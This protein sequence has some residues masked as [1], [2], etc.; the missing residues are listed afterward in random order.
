MSGPSAAGAQ[1]SLETVNAM[2]RARFA[3]ALGAV[4]EKAPWIVERAWDERPFASVAALCAAILRVIQGLSRDAQLDFLRAHPDLAGTALRA[5]EV[6]RASQSEQSGAGL[7]RLGDGEY[8]RFDRLNRAYR[9]KFGFPFIIAVRNHDKAS[10]LAAFDR[11]LGNDAA[12]EIAA[13]LAEIG[14]IIGFRLRSRFA[15]PLEEARR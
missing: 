8:A 5:G 14:E 13:A 9:E 7:D 4:V 11:R 10:I 1:L 15:A 6:T 3:E 12:T 2:D